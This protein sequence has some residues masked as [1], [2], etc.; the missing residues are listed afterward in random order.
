MVTFNLSDFP[1]A[2]L[3]AHGVRAVH[4]DVFAS[5]LLEADPEAFVAAVREHRAALKNPPKSPEAY[6]ETLRNAGLP[7]TAATLQAYEI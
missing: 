4:P 7:Q 3:A 5:N 1:E 2:A 6:L